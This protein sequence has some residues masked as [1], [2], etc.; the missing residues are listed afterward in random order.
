MVLEF[1][2]VL[3][4]R[5]ARTVQ[6]HTICLSAGSVPGRSV[7]GE[8]WTINDRKDQKVEVVVVVL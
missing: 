5:S 4:G 7:G 8:S 2:R 6:S 3:L 1:G